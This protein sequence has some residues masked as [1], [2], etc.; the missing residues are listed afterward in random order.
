MGDDTTDAAER[1]QAALRCNLVVL[2]GDQDTDTEDP[3]LRKTPEVMSQG[4]HRLALGRNFLEAA[5]A[6][7]KESGM[8]CAWSLETVPGAG[9][10]NA[11][12]S[13]AAA[14]V[15]FSGRKSRKSAR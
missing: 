11:Q 6:L 10:S 14:E 5:Q 3:D 4:P 7:A 12:M 13:R 8:A 2:L 15:L 9:H 1:L